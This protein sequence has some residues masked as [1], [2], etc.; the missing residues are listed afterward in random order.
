MADKK[1][2]SGGCHCGKV[3]YRVEAD[4][5]GELIT[6]NCSMCKRMGSM[7]TFVPAT[8]FTLEQGEDALQDY[9]FNQKVIHHLFCKTCG[10]RSFARGQMPDGTPTVAINARCLEDVDIHSL[11]TMEY[12]GAAS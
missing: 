12:N 3:R 8:Q 1:S 11:K 6:C 5:S 2:Y 7:L 4:L 10:I 9:Q